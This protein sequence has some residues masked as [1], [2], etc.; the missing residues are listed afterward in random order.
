MK[1]PPPPKPQK[2]VRIRLGATAS[3]AL[4]DTGLP[5]FGVVGA[6]RAQDGSQHWILY[7]A[8]TRH[9]AALQAAIAI[10]RNASQIENQ[11]NK[12]ES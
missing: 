1:K 11:T 4:D 5:A 6:E 10:M 7:L 3:Q 12:S 9:P 8:E 2:I